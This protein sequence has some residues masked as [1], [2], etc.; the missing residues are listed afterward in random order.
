MAEL[1]RRVS[2]LANRAERMDLRERGREGEILAEMVDLLRELTLDI[3][4]VSENQ[5][6]LE[7]YVE[8][9]DTD[10]MSLE[11]DMYLGEDDDDDETGLF[12]LDDDG[13]DVSYIELECPVCELESSYNEALFSEDGI[14]LTCP[15]CGNVVFDSDEDCLVVDD[16]GDWVTDDDQEELFD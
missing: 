7:E 3:E 2:Q 5:E 6:E 10:L 11:E 16:E 15:H 9:I 13:D 4:E 14:Q 1:R 8:E 12:D